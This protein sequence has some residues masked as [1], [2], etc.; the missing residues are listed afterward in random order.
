MRTN[1]ALVVTAWRVAG[2]PPITVI[3]GGVV[4]ELK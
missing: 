4:A 3:G 1:L 2:W